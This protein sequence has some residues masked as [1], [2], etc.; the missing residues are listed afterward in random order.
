MIIVMIEDLDR[1]VLELVENCRKIILHKVYRCF[2][3]YSPRAITTNQ[4]TNRAPNEPARP[5]KNANLGP[6]LV[7]LEQKILIFTSEIKSF[8]THIMENPPR[9]LVHIVFWSGIGQNV[10]KKAIFGPKWPKMQILGRFW[11]KNPNF[12]GSK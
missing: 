1:Q 5:G 4:P 12:Y 9:H 7:I 10:Q 11:A 6:N 8:V 3:R 2:A